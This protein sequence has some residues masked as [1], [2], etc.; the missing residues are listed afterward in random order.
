MKTMQVEEIKATAESLEHK[1]KLNGRLKMVMQQM[2]A[3]PR[4]LSTSFN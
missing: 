4:L 1:K 3:K 2:E